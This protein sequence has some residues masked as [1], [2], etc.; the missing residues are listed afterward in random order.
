MP[1]QV[2][3]T[4][5]LAKWKNTVEVQPNC[6]ASTLMKSYTREQEAEA[7]QSPYNNIHCSSSISSES[8]GVFPAP[9][10]IATAN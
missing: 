6:V 5:L 9:F 1:N 7:V 3:C 10:D 2:S 4:N 8:K